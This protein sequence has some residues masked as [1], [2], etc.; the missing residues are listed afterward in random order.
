[1]EQF[2]KR[3]SIFIQAPIVEVVE[4]T[5]SFAECAKIGEKEN[6]NPCTVLLMWKSNRRQMGGFQ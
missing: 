1:L 3:R 4:S 6:D 2:H 5:V